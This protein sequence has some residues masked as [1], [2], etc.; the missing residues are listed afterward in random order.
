MVRKLGFS[1]K[2]PDHQVWNHDEVSSILRASALRPGRRALVK[3]TIFNRTRRRVCIDDCLLQLFT[4]AKLFSVGPEK[5][6]K[7]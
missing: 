6:F 7:K 2:T 3:F 4:N 5:K 1:V